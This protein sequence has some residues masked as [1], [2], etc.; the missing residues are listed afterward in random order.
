MILRLTRYVVSTLVRS[1]LVL[2]VGC[3]T[4]N[5]LRILRKA[6]PNSA[7]V[8]MELWFEGLKHAKLRSDAALVQADVRSLPFGKP[9]DLVGIFDVLEHIPDDRGI[10]TALFEGLAPGGCV[11]LTVPAHPSLWS[12]FDEAAH[13][14]RRYSATELRGKLADAGFQVEFLSQFMAS[15]FPLVWFVRKVRNLRPHAA[16]EVAKNQASDEF[17]IIPLLNQVLFCLLSME[18]IWVGNRWRLPFGTSLVAIARKP[19]P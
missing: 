1:S 18:A 19:N 7:V 4:G 17:R 11:V 15:I 13:H 12:Y 6:C 5:V 14:C 2:E 8:G 3:G 9:I 10:L 16:A